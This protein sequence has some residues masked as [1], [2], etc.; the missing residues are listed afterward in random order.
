[1][2]SKKMRRVG[3]VIGGLGAG[4]FGLAVGC[5]DIPQDQ[6]AAGNVSGQSVCDQ[7]TAINKGTL[8]R[9]QVD[10]NVL[11]PVAT[12]LNMPWE[13]AVDPSSGT[14]YYTEDGTGD[15]TGAIK[16]ITNPAT[17]PVISVFVSGADR[18]RRP[19]VFEGHLYFSEYKNNGSIN[20]VN[21]VTGIKTRLVGGLNRPF[22]LAVDANETRTW[23]YFSEMGTGTDGTVKKFSI[24]KTTGMVTGVETLT[25]GLKRPV[26]LVMD[27]FYAY[28]SE[29]DG[30]RV[31]RL[32]KL[33][34]IEND[35]L[36]PSPPQEDLLTGLSTPYPAVL[37]GPND[38]TNSLYFADFNAAQRDPGMGAVYK[39]SNVDRD[40]GVS[41]PVPDTASDCNDG[42]A[43]HCVR[44]ADSLSWPMLVA[45]DGTTVYWSEVWSSAIKRVGKD[46]SIL[47]PTELATGTPGDNLVTPIGITTDGIH[48]YFTDLGN[49]PC[50]F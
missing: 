17:S 4:A 30:G 11:V 2:I 33:A 15:C 38:G 5:M 12:Q 14:V 48:V 40:T 23:V 28:V 27:P 21:L 47:T 32:S 39:L 44:L 37:E 46:G 45:I 34:P 29:M 20:R 36:N 41:N 19:V 7:V 3:M 16:K 8:Y 43:V 6:N 18:P 13:T 24:N 9:I 26:G 22:G 35:T 50:C 31:F 1:M 25:V 10:G 49:N 42:T